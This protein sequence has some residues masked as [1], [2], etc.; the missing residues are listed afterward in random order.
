MVDKGLHVLAV[1]LSCALGLEH[2]FSPK[3]MLSCFV[4]EATKTAKKMR[5]E[6]LGN[7]EKLV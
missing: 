6:G 1:D 4:T 5:R 7:H 2:K 3:S